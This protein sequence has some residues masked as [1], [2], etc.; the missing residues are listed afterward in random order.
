MGFTQRNAAKMA[1]TTMNFGQPQIS[2]GATDLDFDPNHELQNHPQASFFSSTPSSTYNTNTEMS[3]PFTST[4]DALASLLPSDF[5]PLQLPGDVASISRVLGLGSDIYTNLKI[6]AMQMRGRRYKEESGRLSQVVLWLDALWGLEQ[7]VSTI[8]AHPTSNFIQSFVPTSGVF[9]TQPN[10]E[11]TPNFSKALYNST[12]TVHLKRKLL[13]CHSI[14]DT[15]KLHHQLH[16]R[17][18]N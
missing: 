4:D 9:P 10:I 1:T 8:S 7:L 14:Q 16:I 11:P 3:P 2:E 5:Q 17:R 18:E 13:T 15:S 12:T 6:T